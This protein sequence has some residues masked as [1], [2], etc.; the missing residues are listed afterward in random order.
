MRP[1]VGGRVG[2]FDG[3]MYGGLVGEY[4]SMI[5]DWVAE[6]GGAY[7]TARTVLGDFH[8]DN[9]LIL[10][11]GRR[12]FIVIL[13][14]LVSTFFLFHH[15]LWTII[16]IITDFIVNPSTRALFIDILFYLNW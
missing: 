1:W 12:L 16:I 9:L 2:G 4:D 10:C 6:I 3:D 5:H 15:F 7:V 8:V 13:L 11:A 14:L